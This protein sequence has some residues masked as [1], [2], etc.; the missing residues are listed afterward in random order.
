MSCTGK[1]IQ[2]S[3]ESVF[4]YLR[5]V[6][7]AG[8]VGGMSGTEVVAEVGG[9]V[10]GGGVELVVAGA[11]GAVGG[12]SGT[13]VNTLIVTGARVSAGGIELVVAG[14]GASVTSVGPPGLENQ[15]RLI[16]LK[17]KWCIQHTPQ[18]QHPSPF[19]CI[20]HERYSR[21]HHSKD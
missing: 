15:P 1:K 12:R 14:P 18:S 2:Q 19:L 7:P 17:K 11:S 13:V 8:G 9:A 3:P 6:G 5:E 21:K 4:A 16:L 20:L 10:S